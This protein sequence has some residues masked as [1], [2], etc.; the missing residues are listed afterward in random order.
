[1]V[2]SDIKA[3]RLWSL[4]LYCDNLSEDINLE[5]GTTD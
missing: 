5:T 2:G 3:V 1:M 4:I